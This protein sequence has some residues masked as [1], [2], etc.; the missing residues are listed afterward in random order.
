MLDEVDF[1][2]ADRGARQRRERERERPP[3]ASLCRPRSRQL[4]AAKRAAEASGP[5]RRTT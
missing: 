1:E 5:F 2:R 3:L 4:A